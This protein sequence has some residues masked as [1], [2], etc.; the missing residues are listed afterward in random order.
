MHGSRQS[1]SV[2]HYLSAV[3]ET[4]L[5]QNSWTITSFPGSFL[6]QWVSWVTDEVMV[7]RKKEVSKRHMGGRVGSAYEGEYVLDSTKALVN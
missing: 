6:F 7:T 3:G 1:C 5:S 4:I 2:C